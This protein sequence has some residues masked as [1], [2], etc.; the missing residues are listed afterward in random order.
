MTVSSQT[1][2]PVI[3]TNTASVPTILLLPDQLEPT[4]TTTTTTIVTAIPTTIPDSNHSQIIIRLDATEVSILETLLA[5]ANT[6]SSDPLEQGTSP[7]ALPIQVRVAGGWVRDKILGIHGYDID[8]ATDSLSGV[9]FATRV[10]QY[11]QKQNPLQK[12]STLGVIAANPSQSKH[13]ET[14]TMKVHGIAVDFCNLRTKEIYEANS[15]IPTTSFGT[16]KEDAERRDFTIN[17]LF[18][19]I[20]T[21][22]V[23]DWTGRG[24]QD[25]TNQILVTPLDPV[26]T[27]LD[28]PLRVLR[29]IRFAIRFQFKMH[30]DLETACQLPAIHDAVNRKISRERLGKELEGMLSGNGAQPQQALETIGRLNL[31]HC[32]FSIPNSELT[33]TILGTVFGG[34]LNSLLQSG[35]QESRRLLEF[36]NN[37]ILQTHQQTVLLSAV[38]TETTVDGRLL[39]LAVYL[40]PFRHL[41]YTDLKK[42]QHM[43]VEFMVREG[44]KFKNKDVQAITTIMEAVDSFCAFIQDVATS[45][46]TT[47]GSLAICRLKA[48]LLLRATKELWITCL[49]AA[50]I[51]LISK[52]LPMSENYLVLSQR[53]YLDIVDK[54]LD[55]SWKTRPLLDGKALINVLGLPRGPTVGLYME[56]QV[57]WMLLNP[58][59]SK[60][61]CRIYLLGYKGDCESQQKKMK[62]DPVIIQK[63]E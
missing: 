16:P 54:G 13:L 49:L 63:I 47:G 28:D 18:F 58:Q 41:V 31:A 11:I 36:L 59:G 50:T 4:T 44:I 55:L 10:Q 30:P 26:A 1:P 45:T 46:D 25:L 21:R 5:A 6:I 17:A 56:E 20:R 9:A 8:I 14:A 27:L 19:N 2:F 3:D 60:D 53:V 15:R 34:D 7:P 61:E 23:E 40:L 12:A 39:S 62:L 35:W 51:I 32:V 48:G 43:V 37:P 57:R 52:P 33:G 38:K 24:L 29:A 42:K 22:Q